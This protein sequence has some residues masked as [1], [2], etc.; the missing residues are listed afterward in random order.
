MK[1]KDARDLYYF[2]SGKSSDLMRQLA[3]AGLAVI[4]LFKYEVIG[5][6]KV[7]QQLLVPLVLI[8]LGLAFDLFHYV[9]ATGIWGYFHWHKERTGTCEDSEFLAPPKLNWPALALFWM[10]VVSILAAYCLL[11]QYLA[12]TILK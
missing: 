6:P 5:V 7:P 9:V 12:C 2:H 4:W 10:K 1:L 11:L 8:V 3:L